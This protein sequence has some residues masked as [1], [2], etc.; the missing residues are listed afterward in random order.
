MPE[1]Q[2]L[3]TDFSGYPQVGLF[4]KKA[5]HRYYKIRK[6]G[7]QYRNKISSSEFCAETC[8]LIDFLHY[9]V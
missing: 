4:V 9:K 6:K 7:K 5:R 3:V 1:I 8:E 2:D